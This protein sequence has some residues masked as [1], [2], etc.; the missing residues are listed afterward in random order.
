MGTNY[1]VSNGEC[2]PNCGRGRGEHIGKNSYGWKFIFN[3]QKRKSK[4]AWVRYL[5]YETI[6]DEYG[7]LIEKEDFWKMIEEQQKLKG[8]TELCRYDN[9]GYCLMDCDFI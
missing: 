8:Q 7:T 2:C 4:D 9:E 5:E 1:Y 3:G 6:I